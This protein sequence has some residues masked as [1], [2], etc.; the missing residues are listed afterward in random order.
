MKSRIENRSK[1]AGGVRPAR[2]AA[3]LLAALLLLGS[4]ATYRTT[5]R[6]FDTGQV[7]EP[8]QTR[9]STD[10][11][12]ML[13]VPLPG[14]IAVSRGFE[15]GWQGTL[16]WGAHG[17]IVDNE[18]S[19]NDA[20]DTLQGPEV[21]VT[22]SLFNAN[23]SFQISATAGS[24]INVVPEFDA[25]IQAR[26][27]LGWHPWDWFTI[28]ANGGAAYVTASNQFAP[29]V[30]LGLGFDGRF[31]FKIGAYVSPEQTESQR[32]A[33]YLLPWYYGLQLGWKTKAPGADAGE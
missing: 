21:Y 11:V 5:S 23:D 8:G 7:L 9:V 10:S 20:D 30:G 13:F 27:N 31:V 22:K 18:E 3:V 26:L 17:F 12:M 33:D 15:G 4:C 24:D 25:L 29:I 2:L 19:D 14:Q 28:Y 16:G 1:G 6:A 32:S